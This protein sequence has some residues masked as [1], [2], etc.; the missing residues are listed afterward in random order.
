[1]RWEGGG[2]ESVM[3][4]WYVREKT[5]LRER[6]GVSVLVRSNSTS[7]STGDRGEKLLG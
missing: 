5:S 6:L 1:M 2:V 7:G 3:E 4:K